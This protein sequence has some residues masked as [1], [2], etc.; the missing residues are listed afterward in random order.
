M[1]KVLIKSTHS[2]GKFLVNSVTGAEYHRRAELAGNAALDLIAVHYRVHED[3]KQK[4]LFRSTKHCKSTSII[5][6]NPTQCL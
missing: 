6:I 1:E 2:I 4:E 5:T 3:K